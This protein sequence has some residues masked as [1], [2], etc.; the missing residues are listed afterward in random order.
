MA[1]TNARNMTHRRQLILYGT[2][3]CSL[4][5]TALEL[6]APEAA[7]AGFELAE[8]D[9][10]EDDGLLDAYGTR[11]PVVRRSDARGELDWPFDRHALRL[12]LQDD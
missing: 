6:A 10:A 11:I 8:V 9:V 1:M 3:G 12:F 7:R 5:A 4:C 2:L